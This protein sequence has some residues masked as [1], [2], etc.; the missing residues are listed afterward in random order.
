MWKNYKQNLIP[1]IASFCVLV[2]ISLLYLQKISF[3]Q[4]F[5]QR[6]N[7]VAYDLRLRAT[8]SGKPSE[9]TPLYIIDIDEPS[10]KQE[11]QWPWSRQKLA[12][13]IEKLQQ[14]G[15][16][17]ITLDITLAE[18]ETNPVD[19]IHPILLKNKPELSNTLASLR[20][21]L[22][23][24]RYLAN[25]IKEKD[26]I[27]GYLFHPYSNFI[28]GEIIPSLVKNDAPLEQLSSLKMQGYTA[29]LP[30]LAH[31]AAQNGFFTVQPDSDGVVRKAALILEHHNKIY[32]ALAVETAKAYNLDE[33]QESLTLLTKKIAN[34]HTITHAIIAGQKI[35]TDPT[36]Q[37]LIPYIGKVKTFPYISATKVLHD[38]KIPDLSDAIVIIGT[39]A[40]ALA[41]LR[42][43]PLQT[44]YPGVEIQATL[45]HAL[46]NPE[47]IPYSPEWK[48]GATIT[49]FIVLSLLMMLLF[50]MLRPLS[51]MIIGFM[52]LAI[53]TAANLWL[54]SVPRI[55]FDLILPAL[56][57]MLSS[58][59][60]VLHRLILEH[61]QRQHIHNMFGRYVPVGHINRLLDSP[62][63]I[64]MDGERR[65][66]S[67][68]FS[69]IRNFTA[70]SE[71][72]STHKL[73]QFLNIYLTPITAI[74]FKQQGTIDKYIGDLVMAFWGAPLD[75]PQHAEHAVKAALEMRDKTRTMQ[76]E[77]RDLGLQETVSAGTGIHTGEMNV[78]DMG[79]S[80]RRAYTVLGDA[81]NLGSRLESLTKQ[82]GISI[83][84]SEETMLQC[85]SVSF[86]QI[87]HVRVKGR[88][89][90]VKIYEPIALTNTLTSKQEQRITA[91]NTALSFYFSGDW[92]QAK[93]ALL[94]LFELNKEPL[95]Q[96]YLQRM[97]PLDFHSP[98]DWDGVFTHTSK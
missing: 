31:V 39:S 26:V 97:Q 84:T 57:I 54:W 92:Q 81:V 91:H 70:L 82:Y 48:D 36:G 71:G 66:M 65:E 61:N 34:T 67:V 5:L 75:D 90:P 14:A 25:T 79:S 7:S 44:S 35:R 28:K 45:I 10:L 22:D 4:T 98:D 76:K 62:E 47:L 96:V 55:N 3:A 6:L 2:I 29:N 49:L 80:Y 93:K 23:G 17:V 27:L 41:D 33:K 85:P 86:R 32:T 77:F 12:L 64:N 58:T 24:D 30:L 78:G 20:T 74:I 13:L 72:L 8:A 94:R 56:L 50:P 69:D 60:F 59:A 68:L 21:Q 51:L 95:Y 11:G 87:D 9:F 89:E 43:T 63:N 46:L 83:L 18:P 52:L 37:I 42:T 40:Q 1:L 53:I 15:S 88:Q 19:L 73:K 16:A 38:Q